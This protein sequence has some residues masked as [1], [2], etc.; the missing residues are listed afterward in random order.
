ML[1]QRCLGKSGLQPLR[2]TQKQVSCLGSASFQ[3]ARSPTMK[4]A[5]QQVLGSLI[6]ALIVLLILLIR[7][8]P[9]LFHK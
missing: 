2:V 4:I 9:V 8:W 7:A 6:P 3:P 1:Y 5:R